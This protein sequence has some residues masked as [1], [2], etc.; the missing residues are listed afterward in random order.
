M[1]KP[2]RTAPI[3]TY[4]DHFHYSTFALEARADAADLVDLIRPGLERLQVT[5]TDLERLWL[6]LLRARAILAFQDVSLDEL[7]IKLGAAARF[8]DKQN[9]AIKVVALLF[10]AKTPS[11][12]GRPTGSGFGRELDDSELL[13]DAFALLPEGVASVQG[14]LEE[15]RTRVTDGRTAFTALQ[16]A[17]KQLELGKRPVPTVKDDCW[18]L[19]DRL[20]GQLKDRFPGQPKVVASFFMPADVASS[21][22]E[23]PDE[24]VVDAAAAGGAEPPAP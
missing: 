5:K 23:E 14:L 3:S 13:I 22:D 11:V 7:L 19:L 18:K 8:E 6:A 10:G 16:T 24:V 20:E 15:L 9:P 12:M 2:K 4:I 1:P 17:L 21:K